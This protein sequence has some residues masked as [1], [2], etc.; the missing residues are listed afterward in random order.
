MLNNF[1]CYS[2]AFTYYPEKMKTSSLSS[3]PIELTFGG[4]RQS[5]RGND[6]SDM[7]IHV[8]SKGLLRKNFL[9][10]L[11]QNPK[12]VKGRCDIDGNSQSCNWNEDI[13]KYI[14]MDEIP[15]ELIIICSGKIQLSQFFQSN[16]W[17][18]TSFLK[19]KSPTMVPKVHG[20]N[21]GTRIVSRNH[22][23][24]K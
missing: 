7:A 21:S 20:P 1:V 15:N 3:H 10:D 24:N 11:G 17:K 8:V 2:Y 9:N 16:A 19:E 12:T 23:F 13:P 4:I 18:L 14:R 22:N 6:T 5:S